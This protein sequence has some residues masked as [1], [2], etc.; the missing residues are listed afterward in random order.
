MKKKLNSLAL[1]EFPARPGHARLL[2]QQL[3]FYPGSLTVTVTQS[4]L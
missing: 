2:P 4:H 3:P 1:L